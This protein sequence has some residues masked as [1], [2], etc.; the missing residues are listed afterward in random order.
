MAKVIVERPRLGGGLRR[1]KGIRKRERL[2]MADLMPERE[3]MRRRWV[4]WRKMLN[5]H[6]GP[7]RRFLRSQ[8]GRPWNKVHS[9]ISQHLRL[10]SAVQSHVLDHLD[11]FVARHVDEIDGVLYARTGGWAGRPLGSLFYVCPRTGLLRENKR[12][13]HWKRRPEAQPTVERVEIDARRQYLRVSG[14]WYEVQLEP[15]NLDA[16]GRWDEVL[17]TRVDWHLVGELKRHYGSPAFAV[18]KRQLNKREIARVM[19]MW[20][21]RRS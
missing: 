7:L 3:G 18:A 4:S 19:K 20:M 16:I 2:A 21:E 12:R 13:Q 17:K 14:I 8:V 15:L 1:P 9:E 10:D 6:L 11:D 5:E